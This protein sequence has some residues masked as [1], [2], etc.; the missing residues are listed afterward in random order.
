MPTLAEFEHTPLDP[1]D[2]GGCC[3][4]YDPKRD[5]EAFFGTISMVMV[6]IGLILV[7]I[8]YLT[9]RGF[10]FDPDEEARKME[11]IEL[12]YSN[13]SYHLDI[14]ILVGMAFIAFGGLMYAAIF[15]SAFFRCLIQSPSNGQTIPLSQASDIHHY[16]AMGTGNK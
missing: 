15:I 10:K 8:G 3:P 2:D 14:V 1:V 13:L 4:R 16:G 6:A 9:P 5:P 11:A 7:T 12:Y